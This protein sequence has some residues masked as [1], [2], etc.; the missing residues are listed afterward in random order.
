MMV[1]ACF[2]ALGEGESRVRLSVG[3][4]GLGAKVT[5]N[6]AGYFFFGKGGCGVSGATTERLLYVTMTTVFSRIVWASVK[7]RGAT[8]YGG[9]W[10]NGNVRSASSTTT[11]TGRTAQA[12]VRDLYKRRNASGLYYTMR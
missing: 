8:S 5:R 11:T 12:N 10:R 9:V 6:L 7:R 2:A 3:V 1:V 4:T